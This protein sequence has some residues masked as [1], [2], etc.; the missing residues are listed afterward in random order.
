MR[1][2]APP[3]R[4]PHRRGGRSRASLCRASARSTGAPSA[5]RSAATS[6][7]T[8][9]TTTRG[10]TL[11]LTV[12]GSRSA[13]SPTRS[14]TLRAEIGGG[15]L[16]ASLRVTSDDGFA[17][18]HSTLGASG[19]APM[20]PPSTRRSLPTYRSRRSS[21]AW[22]SSHRS[23]RA[24]SGSWMATS[25]PTCALRIDP[26][27]RAVKPEGIV[28]LQDG[29]IEV[30]ALGGDVSRRLG[31][32]DLHPGRHRAPGGRLGARPERPAR[33]CR[34]GALR[35][36]GLRRPARQAAGS[37]EG[38]AAGR[39]RR[40]AGR[41]VL[42]Q[43]RCGCGS[44]GRPPGPRRE[45]GRPGTPRAAPAVR[46]PRGAE[47]SGSIEGLARG[48][49]RLRAA[50]WMPPHA[51]DGVRAGDHHADSRDHRPRKRGGSEARGHARRRPR[52]TADARSRRHSSGCGSDPPGSRHDR[53]A[54]QE[55]SLSR[56]A[57]SPS[58]A[59]IRRIRRSP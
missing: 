31:E 59:T 24:C 4:G 9:S 35:R 38:A 42:R 27:A 1:P 12:A 19:A 58:S 54:G 33:G 44:L 30:V 39:L 45:R 57:R 11:G 41:N 25:P 46:G 22:G 18:A 53:R 3:C 7:W 17:E 16:D 14:P 48:N 49:A 21:F 43:L 2:A 55:V 29:A 13:T 47:R 34:D 6:R 28:T 8:G 56:T 15:Q 50:S 40:R 20:A 32:G 23:S 36:S 51:D 37:S 26:G 5:A 10:A 52:G